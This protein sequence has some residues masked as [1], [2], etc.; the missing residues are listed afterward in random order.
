VE[1]LK[2][3]A[4]Q[5]GVSI[6]S[7]VRVAEEGAAPRQGV[8]SSGLSTSIVKINKERWFFKPHPLVTSRERPRSQGIQAWGVGTR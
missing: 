5:K 8:E 7:L 2:N 3:T 4:G 1:P 6:G